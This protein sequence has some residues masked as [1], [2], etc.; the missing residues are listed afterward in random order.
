[1][2]RPCIFIVFNLKKV[3]LSHVDIELVNSVC[4]SA[5]LVRLG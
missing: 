2:S 3:Y 1:M 5:R 4:F